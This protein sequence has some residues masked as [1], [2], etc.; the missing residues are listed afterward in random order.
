MFYSGAVFYF[1]G[2]KNKGERLCRIK[3]NPHLNTRE[4][5]SPA[6]S[7]ATAQTNR[8]GFTTEDLAERIKQSGL[9]KARHNGRDENQGQSFKAK[10]SELF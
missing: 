7:S 3:Q 8:S 5:S 10:R 4:C 6:T 2:I 9:P 1:R